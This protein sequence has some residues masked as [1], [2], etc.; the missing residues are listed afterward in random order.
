MKKKH[1]FACARAQECV[2]VLYVCVYVLRVY[3][4]V[5]VRLRVCVCAWCVHK[6]KEK[7]KF[8]GNVNHRWAR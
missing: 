4:H 1:A 2:H 3:M 7:N 6:E 5:Y 8:G